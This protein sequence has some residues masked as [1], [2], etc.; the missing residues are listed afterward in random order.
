VNILEGAY[1]GAGSVI[2]ERLTIGK[3]AIVGSG[4]SVIQEVPDGDISWP[5]TRS[6]HQKKDG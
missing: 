1:I 4:A 6:I 2:K 5:V 3:W